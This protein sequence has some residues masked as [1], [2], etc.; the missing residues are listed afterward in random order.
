[1]SNRRERE[2]GTEVVTCDMC[3][4]D[5]EES[6]E[7]RDERTHVCV[8]CLRKMYGAWYDEQTRGAEEGE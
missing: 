4:E 5:A 8:T 3:G 7:S 2:D 6:F 1:M